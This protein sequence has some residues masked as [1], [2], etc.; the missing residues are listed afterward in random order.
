MSRTTVL[1]VL[2]IGFLSLV[3]T[4]NASAADVNAASCAQADV[5]TAINAAG[6]GARVIIPAGN[7]SWSTNVGWQDKNI[8]V[9]GAGID[10]TV[11]SRDGEYIFYVSA[12]A[13]GKAQFR[14]SDM[15]LTGNTTTAAI[16]VT[17][18]SNP[19]INSGWRVDHIKFNY[20]AGERRGVTVRGATYGV[21][22]HNQFIWGQGVAVGVAAFN[23][24]DTCSS[25]NPEGNFINSQPLDLGTAN[26]LYIEDNSFMSSGIG[27]IIV[28][29]DS[30][31]GA[32]TVFRYNTV[33]GGYFYSHWTRGC[34]IGGMVH[35]VYNNTW[36]GN[37]DYND[38]PI[39]L[40]AGTGVIF[41]NT[42]NSY[43]SFPPYV[44]LDDRRAVG[45]GETSVPLGPCDGTSPWDGN[46]G[47][48]AAPGWPCLGQIGR[49]TGKSV[50]QM[51]AGDK[52]ASAPLYLWN[53]GTDAGCSSGGVCTDVL[54]V[55]ATPAA[56][57]KA[58][59]HPNGDVDYV[60]NGK[61]PKPG[62]SPYVYPHPLVSGSTSTAPPAAP[63]DLRV[64]SIK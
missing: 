36:T 54:G 17:T 55:W 16:N 14:I 5:Q 34:E 28:Y 19:G 51:I 62:Y 59:P 57:V 13:S 32:R 56:Y 23:A 1:I 48:P 7:C 18:E 27:G 37:A 41:N 21:V 26:A 22:D 64:I 38:Y 44:I 31:G 10:Q 4:L 47:D 24:S 60:M 52:P 35:E 63:T 42:V 49:S 6:D 12:T 39:R 20:P 46:L 3:P 33:T 45:G 30:A 58:T 61:T 9:K 40:E 2:S 43:Q 11:I 29:D 15:T 8:Y 25:N 53:N 50:A